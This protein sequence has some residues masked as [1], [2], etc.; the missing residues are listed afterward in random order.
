[1]YDGK[2]PA[3][4]CGVKLEGNN[5]WITLIQNVRRES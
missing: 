5:I 3:E 4:S 2:I 1:M